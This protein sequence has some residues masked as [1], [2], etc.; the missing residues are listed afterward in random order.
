MRE[1]LLERREIAGEE[2]SLRCR[3]SI[4]VGELRVGSFACES[5]G[6]KIEEE[7]TGETALAADLTV[8]AQ[9]IDELME[10]LVG[11]QVT[12]AGLEDVLSDW[13]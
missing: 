8:S 9:R 7:S 1:L 2:R 4:L 5:Y 13:L 12:P 3:Y 6:V 10:L 11:G